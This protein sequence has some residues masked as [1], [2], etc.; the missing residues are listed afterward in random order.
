MVRNFTFV[1]C[2]LAIALFTVAPG[3]GT[4]AGSGSAFENGGTLADGGK[5]D[6]AGG[7]ATTGGGGGDLGG[8]ATT[9]G[10]GSGGSKDGGCLPNLVGTL[11]DFHDT[12]PDFEKF[13]ATDKGIVAKALGA[14]FKPVYASAT[15][16]PTTTGKTDFDQWYRDTAGVNT[17]E[18]Y[19]L[20]LTPGAN[21]IST[22]SNS[23]FFPLDGKGFGNE[24]RNHNFHFTYE[25]H[26]EFQYKGGEIFTFT[27]DDDVW[28]FVNKTLAI[29]LGGVHEAQTESLNLD[30]RATE[31]GIVKGTTYDLAIFQAER[32][33][34][35]SNFRVDTSIAFTNC[36]PIIK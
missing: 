15:T 1:P 10:G 11:R 25:L 30:A 13:S 31:L 27:G 12:H 33:T 17:S 21:G 29:D 24:G 36:T 18:L 34:T 9:G 3:C 2:C 19:T 26:T 16:T 35:E 8:G 4:D 6:G 20:V 7:G 28:V 5:R 22:F 32:H 23:A 14:D